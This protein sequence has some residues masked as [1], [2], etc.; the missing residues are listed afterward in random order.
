[1]SGKE[2]QEWSAS[3]CTVSTGTGGT[4]EGEP[5]ILPDYQLCKNGELSE[6]GGSKRYQRLLGEALASSKHVG[7]LGNQSARFPHR[8]KR[9]TSTLRSCPLGLRERSREYGKQS[10]RTVEG[11]S[12]FGDT[13]EKN[14]TAGNSSYYYK[15]SCALLIKHRSRECWHFSTAVASQ[16]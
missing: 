14:Q 10:D 7:G 4:A 11:R 2:A 3:A 16:A 12:G 15:A 6:N 9:W 5:W 13:R 8:G 1:M